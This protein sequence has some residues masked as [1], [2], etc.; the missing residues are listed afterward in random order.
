MSRF[1]RAYLAGGGAIPTGETPCTPGG[2][3]ENTKPTPTLPLAMAYVPTQ[4]FGNLYPYREG[5]GR[6]TLFADLDKPYEGGC[7][8]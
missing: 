3:G 8:K 7:C 2:G 5:W 4:V 6:G 1:Y